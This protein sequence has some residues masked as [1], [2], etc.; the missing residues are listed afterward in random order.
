MSL[1]S[2]L[3]AI[4][5]G[6]VVLVA[7]VWLYIAQS[8]RSAD[9]RRLEADAR[10]NET[11]VGW[12]G[13]GAQVNGLEALEKRRAQ[14]ALGEGGAEDAGGDDEEDA[15][16]DPSDEAGV[17]A[18]KLEDDL[19]EMLQPIPAVEIPAAEPSSNPT[20]RLR[21]RPLGQPVR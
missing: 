7:E 17:A 3:L 1:Q 4:L 6:L 2:I 14:V 5:A 8:S 16:A 9:A 18:R 20:I 12:T 11:V 21:R 19:E 10:R 15:V 13:D